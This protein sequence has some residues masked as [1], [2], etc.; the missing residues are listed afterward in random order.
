MKITDILRTASTNMTHSKVRTFLTIL[1]IF[2][3][4]FTLALTNGIGAGVSSYI[5]K[6]LSSIG[7]EN[8]LMISPKVESQSFLSGIS[9]YDPNQTTSQSEIGI[10]IPVLT[11]ND[12]DKIK[13]Q[14]GIIFVEPMLN[15]TLEY[16]EFNG[17]KYTALISPNMQGIE[18]EI[19]N[20]DNINEEVAGHE[21]IVPISYLDELGVDADNMAGKT[22]LFGVKT[23][24]GEIQE[25]EAVIAGIS[26]Q[27]VVGGGGIIV[28]STL[29][30]SLRDIQLS[31][32]PEAIKNQFAAAMAH[33]EDS[34]SPEE[35]QKIKDDLEDQGYSAM[36]IEDTIG[37][38]KEVIGA[39]TAVLS[40]FAAIALLAASFGIINTLLMA[41]Q[42]RTRE[43]GLMKAMGMSDG[44]VFLLFST[45]AVLIGFWGSILGI[46]VARL[47]GAII[48]NVTSS[49]IL[50]DLPGF[51]LIV[52]SPISMLVIAFIV[53]TIA[54]LAGTLPAR[55]A[56]AQNPIDALRYE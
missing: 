29:M 9:P 2:I 47:A 17:K 20:G 32:M 27:T 30:K 19:I 28:S 3:G 18:Y 7:A 22:L 14:S 5:D 54:F 31:G 13:D 52:F 1:A 11:Q 41:V 21:V 40:F 25:Q 50:K 37:V 23:P 49:T 56:A 15:A 8:T 38:V 33:F 44:K 10:A 53:T 35:V 24:S 46:L 26:Q 51:D 4:S 43:I 12:V 39:I 55:R 48:N 6:Q 34:L 16:F 45:E 36:T 42:E